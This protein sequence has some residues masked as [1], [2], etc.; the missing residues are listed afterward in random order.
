MNWEWI[1][2]LLSLIL[3]LYKRWVYSPIQ[4][5]IEENSFHGPIRRQE[6]FKDSLQWNDSMS[7]LVRRLIRS[8]VGYDILRCWWSITMSITG[9]TQQLATW[10]YTSEYCPKVIILKLCIWPYNHSII[11]NLYFLIF[12]NNKFNLEVAFSAR[13]WTKY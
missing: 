8:Q 13:L 10:T 5:I 4:L 6:Y 12:N 9:F 2:H 11:V 1:A 7:Q 3:P